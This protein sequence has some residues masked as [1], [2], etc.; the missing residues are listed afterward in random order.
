MHLPCEAGLRLAL[1][2][3]LIVALVA[4]SWMSWGSA[5]LSL[6]ACAFALQRRPASREWKG[7]GELVVMQVVAAASPGRDCRVQARI[8]GREGRPVWLSLPPDP[9]HWTRGDRLDIPAQRLSKGRGSRARPLHSEIYLGHA[10]SG[11]RFWIALAKWRWQLARHLDR[12][13]AANFVLASVAGMPRVLRSYWLERLRRSGLGHLTAVS[14][15]HVGS[16]AQLLAGSTLRLAALWPRGALQLDWL[17]V[18]PGLLWSRSVAAL[19][20]VAFV[21]ATGASPSACRAALCWAALAL[22]E[23]WGLSL[24][25]STCLGWIAFA[26]LSVEPGWWE[27]PGFYLSMVATA[28]LIWPRDEQ[29]GQWAASW[30]LFWGLAPLSLFFFRQASLYS[31]L[32]NAIAIPVFGMWVL[33]LA[34][35]GVCLA[36]FS[37]LVGGSEWALEPVL[38]IFALAGQGGKVILAVAQRVAELPGG[39]RGDWALMALVILCVYPRRWTSSRERPVYGTSMAMLWLLASAAAW[40][41]CGW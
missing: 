9:C 33:P 15:L 5:A 30:R 26:M 7:Q 24:H 1:L 39:S 12:D 28:I 22:A 20:V 38:S 27:N 4:C 36:A 35:L 29:S 10:R 31:V 40:E 19:G 8:V 14:G 32:A 21:L 25:R 2:L 3:V 17:P 16:F 13:S 18:E 34:L 41:S 11:S 37:E 6:A 23:L